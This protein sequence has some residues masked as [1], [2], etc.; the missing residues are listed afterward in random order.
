[1][2][3]VHSD[4]ANEVLNDE[5]VAG[6]SNVM[7]MAAVGWS[8]A[9]IAFP[10]SISFV[11]YFSITIVG[12]IF[13]GRFSTAVIGGYGLATMIVNSFAFA[14]VTGLCG[15]LDTLISQAY[16]ASPSHKMISIFAQRGTLCF[17]TLTFP[18]WILFYFSHAWLSALSFA[19]PAI[20]DVTARLLQILIVII[21]VWV[22]SEVLN[23]TL[24]AINCTVELFFACILAAGLNPVVLYVLLTV[25]DVGFEGLGVAWAITIT[26]LFIATC[27][28]TSFTRSLYSSFK[29]WN[30]K[31]SVRRWM[32]L[33]RLSVPSM[34]IMMCEWAAFEVNIIISARFLERDAF[35]A[36]V[37]CQQIYCALL[38]VPVAIGYAISIKVGNFV[39]AKE[40]VNARRTAIIGLFSVLVCALIGDALLV[41]A[42]VPLARL[43]SSHPVVHQIAI[44][45]L[46]YCA[47][48]FTFDSLL[49][50]F[51]NV[52][53]GVGEPTRAAICTTIGWWI[54]GIPLGVLLH[55]FKLLDGPKAFYV[56]PAAGLLV[57]CVL[58]SIHVF[59]YTSFEQNDDLADHIDEIIEDDE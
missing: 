50:V 43:F 52:M 14:A 51:T 33:L 3:A 34:L 42:K 21:P 54:L 35:A 20:V 24:A 4:T 27:I 56:G 28:T 7:P 15:G 25:F 44:D 57:S 48:L 59:L 38:P 5:S 17:L 39:G 11:G 45:T 12:Q 23:T 10:F 19:D 16:G 41:A 6:H 47:L 36:I 8:L 18:V 53:R 1:M 31:Q 13:A 32:P 37:I 30:W 9:E 58:T 29:G 2:I 46:P 40:A 26:L 49:G 55:H 22:V